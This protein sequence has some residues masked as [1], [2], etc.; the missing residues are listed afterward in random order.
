M[1]S[2][3]RRPSVHAS[4]AA[5]WSRMLQLVAE[6]PAKGVEPSIFMLN[7]VLASLK[8]AGQ[9]SLAH[10][11]LATFPTRR[12]RADIVSYNT[13]CSALE[14]SSLWQKALEN[15]AE[16]MAYG[17]SMSVI[18]FNIL[19][20]CLRRGSSW[21]ASLLLLEASKELCTT[22]P[23]GTSYGTAIQ[24]CAEKA[25][26]TQALRLLALLPTCTRRERLVAITAALTACTAGSRWSLGLAL[27]LALWHG[28]Q[29]Q[30]LLGATV[31]ACAMGRAWQ[32]ALAVWDEHGGNEVVC[33][34]VIAACHWA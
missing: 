6:W 30:A 17:H 24:S 23:D 18:S 16:C 10:E 11:F 5:H 7:R 1:L 13:V 29:D 31:A 14:R 8:D 22:A 21:E 4:K 9:G 20:S 3:S 12:L 26:W 15:M 2:R 25:Q 32:L 34:S 19:L 27:C 28:A 33:R